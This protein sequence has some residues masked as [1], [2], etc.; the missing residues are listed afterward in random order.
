MSTSNERVMKLALEALH[1][2]FHQTC[3]V[4]RSK[5]WAQVCEAIRAVE[6]ALASEQEQRSNEQLGEPVAWM[7]DEE[8]RVVTSKQKAGMHE[9]LQKSFLKPLSYTTPQP[10]QK[11][12]TDKMIYVAACVM[13][14][15]QAEACNVDKDDQWKIYGQ[16]FIEDARA[17]LEAAHGITASEAEDSARSKT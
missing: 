8:V 6:E 17:M 12:L 10:A 16:D 1:V 13:N 14:D 5:D 7:D 11:T 3:N 4:G 9:T 2:A 15:R